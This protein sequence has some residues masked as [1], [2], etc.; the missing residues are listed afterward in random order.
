V[1]YW[2]LEIGA[3]FWGVC[4]LRRAFV[5]EWY[6][7]FVQVVDW[8]PME[9][10]LGR[11]SFCLL[12]YLGFPIFG[13]EEVRILNVEVVVQSHVL[14]FIFARAVVDHWRHSLILV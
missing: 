1:A 2:V 12:W 10:I 6:E 9:E 8:G 14:L 11:N 7:V 4:H 3:V 13:L 5:L